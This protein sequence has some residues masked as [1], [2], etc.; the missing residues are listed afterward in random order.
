MWVLPYGVA[1]AGTV[2][3]GVFFLYSMEDCPVRTRPWIAF[4]L[5]MI[6]LNLAAF[7]PVR[8]LPIKNVFLQNA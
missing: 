8:W 1:W 3:V 4:A 2:S 7:A 5:I 6:V